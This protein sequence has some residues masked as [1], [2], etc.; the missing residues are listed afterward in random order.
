MNADKIYSDFTIGSILQRILFI[1][2]AE[3]NEAEVLILS[4][5]RGFLN[6]KYINGDILGNRFIKHFLKLKSSNII[7]FNF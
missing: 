3:I 6:F 2:N 1:C 7:F 4:S 5:Y